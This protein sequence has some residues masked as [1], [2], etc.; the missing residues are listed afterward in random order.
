MLQVP[1]ILVRYWIGFR[2]VNIV[3]KKSVWQST[4]FLSL[5]RHGMFFAVTAVNGEVVARTISDLSAEMQSEARV[6]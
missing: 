5:R 1:A 2:L 3:E 4:W 6:P